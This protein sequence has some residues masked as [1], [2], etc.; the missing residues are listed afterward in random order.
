MPPSPTPD[1]ALLDRVKCE[2]LEMPGLRLTDMQ[3]QRMWGLDPAS[4][5]AIMDALIEARFLFR[6]RDGAVM[7]IDRAAEYRAVEPLRSTAVA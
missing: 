7:R 5:T 6:T 4:C 1:A 3:A 2:F